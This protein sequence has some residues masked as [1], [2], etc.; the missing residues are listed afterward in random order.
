[1][2]FSTSCWLT[3]GFHRSRKRRNTHSAHRNRRGVPR[4]AL[5]RTVPRSCRALSDSGT[6]VHETAR[7]FVEKTSTKRATGKVRS[8]LIGDDQEQ[9][10]YPAVDQ[11]EKHGG[12]VGHQTGH[13]IPP[14]AQLETETA[15]ERDHRT[16][17]IRRT[18]WPVVLPESGCR[19]FGA[20]VRGSHVP[21]RAGFSLVPYVAGG[22]P[23][24]R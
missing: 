12:F 8:D 14:S 19:E 5:L 2:M 22:S 24:A 10:E 3:R 17:G 23:L 20:R 11:R 4:G 7:G 9:C 13:G 21:H 16:R 18:M 15:S 1:M 6:P